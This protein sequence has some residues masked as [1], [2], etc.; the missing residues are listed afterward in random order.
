[1]KTSLDSMIAHAITDPHEF[2]LTYDV[3][4]HWSLSRVGG[5]LSLMLTDK[6]G[7]WL[8]RY[9]RKQNNSLNRPLPLP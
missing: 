3:L 9:F 5:N 2:T 6:Q 7:E 1:M 4:F 8:L